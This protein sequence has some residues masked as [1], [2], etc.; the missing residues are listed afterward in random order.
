MSIV[1]KIKA[2]QVAKALEAGE[3]NPYLKP[4]GPP[5][6]AI[7]TRPSKAQRIKTAQLEKDPDFYRQ[8]IEPT[9]G[10]TRAD[11]NVFDQLKA[12]MQT[13]IARIKTAKN[14]AD[15]QRIKADC[16][17]NYLPF[18]EQYINDEHDYPNSVA[19]QVMVWLLDTGDIE[20]AMHVAGYL[21]ELGNQH[22]PANFKCTIPTLLCRGMYE[23]ADAQLK[24]NNSAEPYLGQLVGMVKT[25][26]WELPMAVESQT[27]VIAAKHAFAQKDF[28]HC[29]ALCVEAETVNPDKA[30]VKTLKAKCEKALGA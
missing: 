5:T 17:P 4:V 20:Q 12:V 22:L 26:D 16:L 6:V 8:V 27:Y 9:P 13:D 28:K 24:A 23:W 15:K 11:G 18:V 3:P 21:I 7:N 30:G 19:V 1:E 2:V 10:E 25:S 29:L 14:I